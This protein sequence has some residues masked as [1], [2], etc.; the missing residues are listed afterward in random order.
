[1]KRLATAL[2]VVVV[3]LGG[4][5]VGSA[6]AYIEPY[7]GPG[8]WWSPGRQAH[9]E[10]DWCGGRWYSNTFSRTEAR[11]GL[12]TFINANG[13]WRYAKQDTDRQLTT[14][15]PAGQEH[16]AKKPF[17]RNTSSYWQQGGCY[18]FRRDQQGNCT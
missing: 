6:A 14:V 12:V 7:T 2:I 11:V 8:E 5:A 15:I 3:A 17:C 18:G 1:M 9:G 13:G 16:F 10:Y 4:L